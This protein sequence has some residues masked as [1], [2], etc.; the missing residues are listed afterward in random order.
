MR[1][2]R[3]GSLTF[4]FTVS[5]STSLLHREAGRR[6]ERWGRG[7]Q[8]EKREISDPEVRG[9]GSSPDYRSIE[10]VSARQAST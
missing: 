4:L 10:E 8:K 1:V 2:A 7:N 6:R 5:L 9:Q 3:W